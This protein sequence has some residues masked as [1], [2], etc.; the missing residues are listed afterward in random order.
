MVYKEDFSVAY[1]D[2]EETGRMRV[3]SLMRAMQTAGG[4][5][6]DYLELPYEKLYDEDMVFLMAKTSLRVHKMPV[7]NDKITINTLPIGTKGARFLRDMAFYDQEGNRMV[8]LLSIWMLVNPHTRKI[9]RPNAFPFP[10]PTGESINQGFVEEERFPKING[11]EPSRVE[12][13]P[14]LYS[15]IDNNGHVNNSFYLDFACDMIPY[16]EIIERGIE[17]A[18]I[19]YKSEAV[20][21]DTIIMERYDLPENKYYILGSVKDSPSFEVI[22]GLN[23][24]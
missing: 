6:L 15:H 11:L 8:S 4:N 23:N 20:Y 24:K 2:C 22:I 18:T 19:S 16:N 9:L 3:S 10:M 1:Y 21:G 14:T 5:H 13:M 7:A 12:Q 17:T